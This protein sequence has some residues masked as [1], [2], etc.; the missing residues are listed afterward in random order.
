MP[1]SSSQAD[2]PAD[3]GP[4]SPGA[5]VS[6]FRIVAVIHVR[7]IAH[8]FAPTVGS[9][10]RAGVDKV[11]IGSSEPADLSELLLDDRV[12][13]VV[14]HHGADLVNEVSQRYGCTVV[15]CDEPVVVSPDA[16]GPTAALIARD[17]RAA[18]VSYWC[19]FAGYLSF[20][21]HNAPATHQQG[22]L[23]ERT[24]TQR[25]RTRSPLADPVCIPLARGPL[26]AIARAA[27]TACG[28]L[29]ESPFGDLSVSVAEFGLRAMARGFTP[30]L[31]PTTYVVRPFDLARPSETTVDSGPSRAWLHERHTS[32][33]ALYDALLVDPESPVAQAHG[34][35]R[36]QATGL[37]LLI[38][39]SVL[40]PIE[41]GTQ[42]H[43]VSLVT[44]LAARSDVR[45]IV[46]CIPGDIPPYAAA[47]FASPKV[48][49]VVAL[50]GVFPPDVR[51]DVVHRPY[52][53]DRALPWE[54]WRSVARRVV[55]TVQDLIAYRIGDYHSSPEQW[56]EY[57]SQFHTSSARADGVV[58]FVEDVAEAIRLERLSIEPARIGVMPCGTDHL[59]GQE[60]AEPPAAFL[61]GARAGRRFLVVLGTTYAHKNRD[62]AV[63]AWQE[64]RRRGHE[65]DL[66]VVGAQVP[67]GS[68]RHREATA[69]GVDD[70]GVVSLL[71]A[72]SEERNW[73]LRHAD[74]VLYPS[75]AEGFGL[76]PFEAAAFGTPTVSV[77]FGPLAEVQPDS[78]HSAASWDPA[79]LADAVAELLADPDSSA[80]AVAATLAAGTDYTWAHAGEKLVRIYRAALACPPLSGR[81]EVR[82]E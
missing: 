62:L 77:H 52:Q 4:A 24:G 74:A 57:R 5:P 71:D 35:A 64:L 2:L 61:D 33:P 41:T 51:S 23:D 45:E 56:L 31:D 34:L 7:D 82:G 40:G 26:V 58:V 42:V 22:D 60:R 17:P 15:A 19:N 54:H 59:T 78:E 3:A 43:V 32:F 38:D 79:D 8:R 48:H 68:S 75:S 21:H 29:V 63:R 6:G 28:P 69:L 81:L 13:L 20:P 72:T 76:V 27:L 50:D 12:E 70:E 11:V 80:A 67:F 25:L 1:P 30:M 46:V 66:V 9:L 14:A 65:H 39:G 47:T 36:A 73:L 10:L 37:R 55:I 53:P 18:T 44:A 49:P 16:F